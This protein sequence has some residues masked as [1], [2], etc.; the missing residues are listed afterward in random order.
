MAL[1]ILLNPAQ[2]RLKRPRLGVFVQGMYDGDV[3]GWS[4]QLLEN[5]WQEPVGGNLMLMPVCLADAFAWA[6]NF[7]GEYARLGFADFGLTE[8][9][10][11]WRR[12]G[13]NQARLA[14][15]EDMTAAAITTAGYGGDR[16]FY[17]S[18]YTF[19]RGV[20]DGVDIEFGYGTSGSATDPACKLA[21]QFL[22]GGRVNVNRGG[23]TVGQGNIGGRLKGFHEALVLPMNVREVLVYSLTN[24]E[25][26]IHC[27]DDVAESDPTPRVTPNVPVWFY[28]PSGA[29]DVEIAPLRFKTSGRAFSTKG[30]LAERPSDDEA[31]SGDVFRRVEQ[32]GTVTATLTNLAGD[33]YTASEDLGIR[34]K[35]DLTGPGEYTPFVQAAAGGF[36]A[37]TDQTE[38]THSIEIR[39]RAMQVRLSV[40]ESP[41]DVRVSFSAMGR[42][43]GVDDALWDLARLT[44]LPLEI[45]LGGLAPFFRGQSG[46]TPQAGAATQ[47]GLSFLA[48][49]RDEWALTENARYREPYPF[50][51]LTLTESLTRA[52]AHA[53]RGTGAQIEDNTFR[54]PFV[55]GGA[56]GRWAEIAR[57]GD[58][59]CDVLRHML[60]TYAATW[61]YGYFPGD[62]APIFKAGSPSFFGSAPVVTLYGSIAEAVTIGGHDPNPN[63]ED[64]AWRFVYH[65]WTETRL[66]VEANDVRVT[67][68][69]PIARRV[70]QARYF[71]PDSADPTLAPEDRPDNWEG[72]HL[73]LGLWDPKITTQA[74]CERACGI[75]AGRTVDRR[76]VGAFSAEF[77]RK[78]L[79]AG[80]GL[81][82]WKGAVVDLHGKG[83]YRLNTLEAD[84]IVNEPD[85]VPW[86]S[87]RRRC[88]ARYTAVKGAGSALGVSSVD[89]RLDRIVAAHEKAL[90][91]RTRVRPGG[92]VLLNR[93]V[94]VQT[95][96]TILYA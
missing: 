78:P 85:E 63:S 24:A 53:G 65:D 33:D 91:D 5:V 66:R 10:G 40:P 60:E 90:A 21:L 55:E 76:V 96:A 9:V 80:L 3:S 39:E 20:S 27:F 74:A 47:E 28:R 81:P 13:L 54:L 19:D 51:D 35:V 94:A 36:P 23:Q 93:P 46:P 22:C 72:E 12:G 2:E 62:D 30:A 70:I 4:R 61:I 42:E 64:A 82:L 73:P 87:P 45:S 1:S 31:Y 43:V 41:T 56:R 50:D 26:F 34:I 48:E 38:G 69:D 68:F 17:L 15:D 59:S 8:G 6:D 49:F 95:A 18:W 86:G 75:L 14:R 92:E 67:G 79:E 29:V 89:C 88:R 52:L 83:T 11:G 58:P 44:N 84:W 77:A 71:D 37:I 25:G 57:S 32:G 16:G 7:T